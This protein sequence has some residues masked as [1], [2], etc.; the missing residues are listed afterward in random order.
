MF[1]RMKTVA[2]FAAGAVAGKLFDDLYFG[3]VFHDIKLCSD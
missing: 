3:V 2:T 1:N